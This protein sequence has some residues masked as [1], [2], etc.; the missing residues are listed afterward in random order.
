MKILETK[1][2]LQKRIIHFLFT[3]KWYNVIKSFK[4]IWSYKIG[5]P[6]EMSPLLKHMLCKDSI[7]LDIGA[8]MGQYACRFNHIVRKGN[9]HVHSFEPV[10]GNFIALALMKNKLRLN[11]VTLNQLGVSNVVG[12]AVIHIPVFKNGLVVG[13][14]ASLI[15][16]GEVDRKEELIGLTTI[17]RYVNDNK[18]ERI[19]LIKCDTEGNENN[20]LEGAKETIEK[21]LPVLSFE[22]SYNE[23]GVNWL[24]DLGYVLFFH[25]RKINKLRKV[26]GFQIG[27][28]ILV[29]RK[30]IYRMSDIIENRDFEIAINAR[31]LELL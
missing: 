21:H 30:D 14:R 25:D 18:I 5:K 19:D 10:N 31:Q 28:L 16:V 17:D 23:S 20:V 3:E 27:N 26:D 2:Y 15:D 29:H 6:Y 8:N 1:N 11:K 24:L 7:V 4:I 22:M 9:G 12:K 13:T